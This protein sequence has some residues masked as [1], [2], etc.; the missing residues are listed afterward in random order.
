MKKTTLLALF[1]VGLLVGSSPAFGNFGSNKITSGSYILKGIL[2]SG[3]VTA[4]SASYKV[5]GGLSFG[6][7]HPTSASYRLIDQWPALLSGISLSGS[8]TESSSTPSDA[9]ARGLTGLRLPAET[10]T[11]S[12]TLARV[13]TGF[14]ALVES[15]TV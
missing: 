9:L 7:A 4:T 10:P 2:T 5:F 13:F 14:R 11:I 12:D 6:D 15:S 8:P 3:G 1:I